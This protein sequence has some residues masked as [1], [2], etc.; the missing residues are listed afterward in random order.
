[1][2]TIQTL[3]PQRENLSKRS[4]DGYSLARVALPHFSQIGYVAL[5]LLAITGTVNS[6]MLVGSFAAFATTPYGRLLAVKILLFLTMT[7]LALVNRFRLMPRLRRQ[8]AAISPLR[9]LARS[10]LAANDRSVD[11]RRRRGARHLAASERKHVISM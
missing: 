5:A 6:V 1:M 11:P 8:K 7:A 3:T 2:Q 4:S 10:V 9:T